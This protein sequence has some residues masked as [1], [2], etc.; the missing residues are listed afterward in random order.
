MSRGPFLTSS[1]HIPSYKILESLVDTIEPSCC[2][3]EGQYC[4]I[5]LHNITMFTRWPWMIDH[6]KCK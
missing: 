6:N 5:L 1:M 4:N 2:Y 3:A